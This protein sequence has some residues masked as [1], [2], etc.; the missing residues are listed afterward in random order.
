MENEKNFFEFKINE[1][2]DLLQHINDSIRETR[3]RIYFI[4]AIVFA[5]LS[6]CIEDVL[7]KN[8]YTTKSLLLYSV[9]VFGGFVLY[10]CRYAYTPLKLR[11]NGISPNGF[12]MIINN[13]NELE[14]IKKSILF[15]YQRSIEINGNHLKMIAKAYNKALYTMMFWLLLS[16]C[17]FIFQWVIKCYI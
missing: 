10:Q 3:N 5:I 7:E 11:F 17:F 4:I 1:A 9:I 6:F 12:E 8:Y 15:T 13:S 16:F 2:K 14:K